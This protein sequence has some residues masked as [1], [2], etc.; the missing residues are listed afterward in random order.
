MNIYHIAYTTESGEWDI[1]DTFMAVDDAEANEY[2]EA[3]Y[4]GTEWYV[5]D[6]CH[7]NING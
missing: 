6:E 4:A 1:I 3:N 7:D 2:A 5:I